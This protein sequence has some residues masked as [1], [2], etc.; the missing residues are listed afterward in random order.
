MSNSQFQH[1]IVVLK[2]IKFL[3]V[4]LSVL[5]A[6]LLYMNFLPWQALAGTCPTLEV[7]LLLWLGSSQSYNLLFC[8]EPAPQL[9]VQI[10]SCVQH[11]PNSSCQNISLMCEN[12]INKF[13]Y[14]GFQ[15]Q[16]R[17]L[18]VLGTLQ[19]SPVLDRFSSEWMLARSEVQGEGRRWYTNKIVV[20]KSWCL[21]FSVYP[22]RFV[23]LRTFYFFLVWRAK[24]KS[25]RKWKGK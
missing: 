23:F 2:R 25:E 14:Y 12:F 8:L 22:G 16:K 15:H 17:S 6:A 13:M 7:L 11:C 9:A 4:V 19:T 3:H 24:M 20:W 10:P 5:Q 18:I 21:D 1:S